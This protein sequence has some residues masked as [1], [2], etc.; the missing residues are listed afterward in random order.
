[1]FTCG[2]VWRFSVYSVTGVTYDA[3]AIAKIVSLHKGG[4]KQT[5]ITKTKTLHKA[6]TYGMYDNKAAFNKNYWGQISG[7]CQTPVIRRQAVGA[8]SKDHRDIFFVR[9]TNPGKF[10]AYQNMIVTFSVD[11]NNRINKDFDIY[12]TLK[13]AQNDKNPW[14]FASGNVANIGFPG[15]SGPTKKT[16]NQWNSLTA[17]PRPIKDYMYSVVCP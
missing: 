17:T 5:T 1:M 16:T 8:T 6:G 7:G 3:A 10:D 4:M 13:D 15:D 9:K 14:K 12:S 11:A 2:G